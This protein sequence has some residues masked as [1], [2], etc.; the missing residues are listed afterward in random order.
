MSIVTDFEDDK[1]PFRLLNVS[2]CQQNVI[3]SITFTLI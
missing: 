2:Q 1:F 3:L